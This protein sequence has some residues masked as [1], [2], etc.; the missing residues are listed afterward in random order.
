MKAG[1]PLSAL[2]RHGD[3]CALSVVCHCRFISDLLLSVFFCLC[4]FSIFSVYCG[5]H[6]RRESKQ[7]P[8]QASLHRAEAD[9]DESCLELALA[10][11]S[12]YLVFVFV[13]TLMVVC[14]LH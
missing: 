2:L 6:T 4:V 11:V 14:L 12:V 3:V 8:T 13:C 1:E 5:C 10:L 9:W 7:V